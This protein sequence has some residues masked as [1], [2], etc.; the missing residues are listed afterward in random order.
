MNCPVCKRDNAFTL[1]IC[2]SCG[3]MIND[4]VREELVAK[5]TPTFKPIPKPEYLNLRG[6]FNV[7]NNPKLNQPS[8]LMNSQPNFAVPR[9]AEFRKENPETADFTVKNTSPTLVEFQNKNAT[10]P[11]WRL[12]LKN[13]VLQRNSGSTAD[14]DSETF[15]RSI[16]MAD[17]PSMRRLNLATSGANALKVEEVS[18]ASIDSH[19]NPKLAAALKRIETSRKRFLEVEQPEQLTFGLPSKPNNSLLY[20]TAKPNDHLPLSN[21]P[22]R[23]EAGSGTV[24][25]MRANDAKLDTNKLPPL[26]KAAQ[27]SSSFGQNT[28][29]TELVERNFGAKQIEF[30]EIVPAIIEPVSAEETEVEIEDL[31][32]QEIDD[33]APIAMRFNSGLFDLIIGSFASLLLLVPFMSFG[34]AWF[35]LAGIL[36]FTATTSIVMFIYLTTAVALYGRTFGMKLFSLEII[37]IEGEEYPTIHQA[38]VSS[39]VYLISL[40]FAGS[41]FLTMFF[42]DENRAAHDLVSRTIVVKEF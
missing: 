26:P 7:Q 30:E 18:E 17:S 42:N 35:G 2:P 21:S 9:E 6:D 38:A 32:L 15:S 41:G 36:A 25:S 24:T 37:D 23:F 31:E 19:A 11:E 12:Q 40:L 5:V 4:S 29:A 16:E 33:C 1:S 3:T 8:P 20:F 28:F 22:V 13:A 34:G 14:S 10:L 27:I 39:A